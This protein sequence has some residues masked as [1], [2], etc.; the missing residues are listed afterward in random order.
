[1]SEPDHNAQI[2]LQDLKKS[3]SSPNPNEPRVS[4]FTDAECDAFAKEYWIS[5][6]DTDDLPIGDYERQFSRFALSKIEAAR[7]SK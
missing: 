2:F 1:M 7:R 4:E 5:Q 6:G 3:L